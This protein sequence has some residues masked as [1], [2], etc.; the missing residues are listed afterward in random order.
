M[1]KERSRS[2]ARLVEEP[3]EASDRLVLL[4]RERRRVH[5]LVVRVGAASAGVVGVLCLHGE[6]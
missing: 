2:G 6:A 3:G 4:A 1:A 5:N